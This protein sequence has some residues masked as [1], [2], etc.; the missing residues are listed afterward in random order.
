MLKLEQE[1][2]WILTDILLAQ[3]LLSI[4]QKGLHVLYLL[5]F[6]EL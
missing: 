1:H 2:T 3:S 6:P 4:T 5:S